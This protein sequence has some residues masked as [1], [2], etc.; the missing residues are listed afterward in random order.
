MKRNHLFASAAIGAVLAGTLPAQAQILGGGTHGGVSGMQTATFGGG[1]GA[2]HSAARSQTDF[3]ASA[4]ARGQVDGLGRLDRTAKTGTQQAAHDA[5]RAKG[6]AVVA[7][8]GA[9]SAG[10]FEATKASDAA[11]GTSRA[12]V[13]STAPSVTSAGQGET[14]VR[15]V[16]APSA[17]AGGLST[18]EASG[19][20]TQAANPK[21]LAVQPVK[22]VKPDRAGGSPHSSA[23]HDRGSPAPESQSEG[24]SHSGETARSSGSHVAIDANA[25]AAENASAH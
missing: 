15:Y 3:S 16:D 24:G 18:A 11:L 25:S 6:N 2:P 14:Q 20:K 23:A 22:P 9:V 1:F 12:A 5:E 21:P 17:V 19:M 10:E 13:D 4:R 8:R 7:G